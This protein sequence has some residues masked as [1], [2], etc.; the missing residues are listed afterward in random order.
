MRQN[1]VMGG[2]YLSRRLDRQLKAEAR[3][4]GASVQET[5]RLMLVIGLRRRGHEDLGRI[6]IAFRKG[7]APIE[8]KKGPN[9]RGQLPVTV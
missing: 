6:D 3:A 9:G 4:R 2:L 7:K 8:V 1:R 5:I